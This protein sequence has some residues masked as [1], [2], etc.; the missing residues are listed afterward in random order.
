M[1]AMRNHIPMGR[2]F[3]TDIYAAPGFFV[4]LL[5]YFVTGR[6]LA[7]SALFCAAVV[8]SLLVHEFGHV[9]AVRWR[10][11]GSSVV[12]LWMLGGLCIHERVRR[13]GA[14]IVISLMGPAFG[15]ALGAA[16]WGLFL[17]PDMHPT[18]HVFAW[19]L[20]WIGFL[21]NA[22]NLIPIHPLDGGQAFRAALR[23]MV[24]PYHADRVARVVSVLCAAAGLAAAVYF[25][26]PFAA[27]LAGLLLLQNL[28]RGTVSYH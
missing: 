11:G 7:E 25:R 5:L 4:L 22:L 26:R 14:Q 17:V 21:W 6:D 15:F 3:G 10:T 12:L 27:V 16:G 28:N 1:R 20:A 19:D 24:D 13:P 18:V 2:L 9:F 23:T 8:L